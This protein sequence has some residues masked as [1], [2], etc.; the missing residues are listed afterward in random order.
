ML[1]TVLHRRHVAYLPLH[2]ETLA[3]GSCCLRVQ[4]LFE[5]LL[6]L[7]RV[8]KVADSEIV[9]QISILST[10]C[11]KLRITSTYLSRY[12]L[13]DAHVITTR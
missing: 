12:K 13:Y 7:G 9:L 4:A 8:L 10:S 5:D 3:V 6:T 11:V 1:E 2:G